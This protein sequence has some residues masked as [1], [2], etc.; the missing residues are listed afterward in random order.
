MER[1]VRVISVERGYDPRSFSLLAFG[2]AG[3][4]HAVSIAQ[5]LGIPKVVVPAAAGVLSAMGLLTCEAGR[6]YGRSILRPLS[7]MDETVLLK[8]LR[9]LEARGLEELRAEG[10][11]ASTLRCEI[12]ADLRYQGQSHE[13][14]IRLLPRMKVALS[15]HDVDDWAAAFHD[16]HRARYGHASPEEAIELVTLRLRMTAPPAFSQLRV[17]LVEDL[18]PSH[19]SP[20]WFDES[21][22]VDTHIIDRRGLAEDARVCGPAV[23][24]GTDA[25]LIVPPGVAGTC[26]AMGT[27][28]LEIT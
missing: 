19:E 1:A 2:G 10:I 14:N 28:Q 11:D 4:L 24:W 15:S 13:L 21:G 25:T 12:S 22:P 7:A 3:P 27:V 20:V 8:H 17:S 16:E 6:D 26:N 23:L 18:L 9:E 5:R